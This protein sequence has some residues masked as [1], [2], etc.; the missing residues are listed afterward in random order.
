MSGEKTGLHFD[1]EWRIT[2]FTVVM[3]PLMFSLGLWQ[4]QRADDQARV[5]Q[6]SGKVVRLDQVHHGLGVCDLGE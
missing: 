3:V 1:L 6:G 4:L 2:L 5:D